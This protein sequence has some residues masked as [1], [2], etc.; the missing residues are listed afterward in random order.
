MAISSILFALIVPLL[1]W[2]LYIAYCPAMNYA[3]ARKTG[4]PLVVLPV[5]C[6]NPLWMSIDTRVLPFVR[7]LPFSF[8]NFTRFS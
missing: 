3:Q 4:L 6:G 7:R 5:D 1:G 8:T 2:V